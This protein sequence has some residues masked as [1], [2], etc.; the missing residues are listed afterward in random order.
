M[1]ALLL[2]L[3]IERY[4]QSITRLAK[5]RKLDLCEKPS[6]FGYPRLSKKY[7][8]PNRIYNLRKFPLNG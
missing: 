4:G 6:G 8:T 7:V 5:K 2:H 3:R 1:E